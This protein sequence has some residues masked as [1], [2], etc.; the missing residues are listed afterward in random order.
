M[1]K[2]DF[3]WAEIVMSICPMSTPARSTPV[4]DP[5]ENFP[6]FSPPTQ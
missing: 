5:R 4:T 1:K 2:T 6:N 3:T